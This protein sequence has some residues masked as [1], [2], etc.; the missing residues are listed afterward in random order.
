ME[1]ATVAGGFFRLLAGLGTCKQRSHQ[2]LC[3]K[4]ATVWMKILAGGKDSLHLAPHFRKV[5]F[6]GLTTVA[7][8]IFVRIR[9]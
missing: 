5:C 4:Y 9:Y 1:R 7:C 6:P 3:I 8:E 2:N